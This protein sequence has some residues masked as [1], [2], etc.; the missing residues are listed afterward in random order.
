MDKPNITNNI[1]QVRGIPHKLPE[2]LNLEVRGEVYM[3]ISAFEKL[4]EENEK[5][6][7]QT[8][9]DENEEVLSENKGINLMINPTPVVEKEEIED[10]KQFY[11]YGEKCLM[12]KNQELI[13]YITTIN[14]NQLY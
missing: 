11:L 14:Y 3:E 12:L 9:N 1:K 8:S 2:P 10:I 4:N 6:E 5:A 7:V 13:K